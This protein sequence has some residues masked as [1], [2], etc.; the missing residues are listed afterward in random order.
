MS[1]YVY[2]RISSSRCCPQLFFLC[3]VSVLSVL[4][5][6]GLSCRRRRPYACKGGVARCCCRLRAT[7][8]PVRLSR[9]VTSLSPSPPPSFSVVTRSCAGGGGVGHAPAQ[10]RCFVSAVR[11]ATGPVT[12]GGPARRH[13]S[14]AWR[15]RPARPRLKA[16]SSPQLTSGRS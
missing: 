15:W 14:C 16:S 11:L 2:S 9:Q 8:F 13:A 4:M 10:G 1:V 5:F 7:R 12:R 3:S 6:S